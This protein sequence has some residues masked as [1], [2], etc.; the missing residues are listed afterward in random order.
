MTSDTKFDPIFEISNLDYHG[1]HV[2]IASLFLRPLRP[3]QPPNS[4][5]GNIRLGVK[6]SVL[7]YLSMMPSF[8]GL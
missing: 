2:H 4:L 1:I 5:V 7:N 8:S 6:L 3:C